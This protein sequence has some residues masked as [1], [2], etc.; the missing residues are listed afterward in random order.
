MDKATNKPF[1]VDGKEIIGEFKCTAEK[2]ES[3]V[4]FEFKLDGSNPEKTELVVF[5]NLYYKDQ[6]IT[7]HSDITDEGQTVKVVSPETVIFEFNGGNNNDNVKTGDKAN[8]M[9]YTLLP[10]ES[11]LVIAIIMSARKCVNK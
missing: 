8:L 1:T 3:F 4:G 7:T 10:L 6:D 11:I 5:E 9:L 2:S